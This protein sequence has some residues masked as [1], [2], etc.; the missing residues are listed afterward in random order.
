MFNDISCDERQQRWMF[1]ECQLC[2]DICE[3]IWCW[4]M[5]ISWIRFWT[6]LVFCKQIAEEMLLEF[7]ERGHP[8][9]RATTPLSRGFLKSTRHGKLSIQQMNR[10]LKHF[11]FRIIISVNQLSIYGAVAAVCEEFED[12]QDRT[13]EPEIFMGQSIVLGE[14]KAEVPLQNENPLNRHI[15]WQ[16]YTERI[17]S[18]SPENRFSKFCKDTEFVRIVEVG[19]HFVTKPTGDFRQFRSVACREYTLPRDVPASQPKGWIRGNMRIGPV[20][21]ITTSFQYFKDGIEIQIKFVNQDDSHSWVRNLADSRR[22]AFLGQ[23]S[24][25]FTRRGRCTNKLRSGCSQVESKSE[26]I[27]WHDD[28][29]TKWKSMDWHWTIKA[30]SRIIQSLEESHQFSS[31]QSE[32]TSRRRWSNPILQNQVPSTRPSSSNTKLVRWSM[33]SLFGCRR[34]IQTKIS[35]LFWLLGINYLSPCSS[36]TFWEQSHWSCATGQR[37]DW[38]WNIP[39]H[40]PCGKQFQSSF[41]Y[42]QWTCTWRWK[43][44]QKTNS[45]LL[46]LWSKKWKS[47]RSR[48]YR[49]LCTA[50]RTILAK[51]MEETLRYGILGRY[52]SW[53]QRRIDVQSDKIERNYSSRNTS[54][55]LHCKSWK[56]EKWRKLFEKQNLSPR[57]PPKISL[58]HD[59]NW[60]RRND[61]GLQLNI[62]Q[63]ANS[64]NS[65]LEKHFN[66][67]LPSQPNSPKPIEDRTGQP[68]TQD[69]VGKLQEELSSV[70]DEEKRVLKSHDGT[71]QPV[72]GRLHKVQEDGY[73]QNRDDADKFN[74]AMDDENI[75]FNISGIPDAT[76]KRSQSISVHD[77]I[78]KI[79]SHTQKETIQ[80]DLEQHRP[81]NP[82]SAESKVAIMAAGNTELCEIINVE[83]KF[84]NERHVLS[85]A[86]QELYTAH[87]DILWQIILLRTESTSH[88]CLIR[89]PSRISTSGKAGH[90]VTGMEKHLDAK[91]TIRRINWQEDAAKR[92]MTAS[93]IDTS[94]TNPSG[95]RWLKWDVLER[96]SKR[97]IS[98]QVK[99]TLTT[100]LEQKLT[101]TVATGGFTQTWQTSIRCQQGINL[102]SRRRTMYRLKQAEDEK[103]YA[104]WSQSSSS[105]QWQTNW[106]ESD[107]EYSPQR[108]YD[109]WLKWV[110]RDLVA[111]YSFALWV[112]A[113]I[114]IQNFYREY[115]GYSWRQSTVIDGGCKYNTSCTWNSR[116]FYDTKSYGTLCTTSSTLSLTL[117]S[118]WPIA[119]TT[120]LT[121]TW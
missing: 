59:R 54:S 50:S 43:F 105:W 99:T 112:S 119:W 27:Y 56:I 1:K 40:L 57:P 2:K 97:W 86:V 100:P 21:E 114:W 26:G 60:S 89:S 37:V 76:V 29:P 15:L 46:T 3:K 10:Q 78:Q 35:V 38:T 80:N 25:R 23:K 63:L 20:L 12:H 92:S 85:I 31:T 53:N 11:F 61:Q 68:V 74:L 96:S 17:E 73:L 48:V 32:I 8:T 91:N 83:P 33:D 84:C 30:R 5:V 7:A 90:T 116:T 44:E 51:C 4:S 75:D 42:Q 16:Q 52:W 108:W 14:I 34:R 67:V 70:K 28:H 47:Q 102:I 101:S 98:L 9:F 106:W 103:Q 24:C 79:E 49:L 66:L 87:V 13:G 36:R 62:D 71:E 115:I 77:L 81:F 58:K 109:H 82:F 41:N 65:H 120:W 72:E 113:R 55:K 45:V 121:Q 117:R 39:W 19:Q 111:N 118:L 95:R 18:L 6:E 64:F 107:Y 88:P 22:F 94:A 104:K 93:T 69:I 110:T